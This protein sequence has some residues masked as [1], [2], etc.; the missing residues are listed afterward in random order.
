MINTLDELTAFLTQKISVLPYQLDI[1]ERQITESWH[2]VTLGDLVVHIGRDGEC[3]SGKI[4]LPY[5]S[6]R[7]TQ[8]PDT[9]KRLRTPA[10]WNAGSRSQR[11]TVALSDYTLF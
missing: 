4:R 8:V 5:T 10:R 1:A 3:K 11:V 2:A 7:T 9:S 6:C